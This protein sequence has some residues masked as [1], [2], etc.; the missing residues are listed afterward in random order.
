MAKRF[1][2][3]E[4]LKR[5]WM[6][7]LSIPHK[8]LWCYVL[9]C[10]DIAGVWYVDFGMASFVIGYDFDR[11]VAEKAFEKQIEVNGDRW[12]IKDFISFQYGQMRPENKMFRNVQAKLEAFKEGGSI[13]HISPINGA[14]DK[15][16]EEEK[17][18][19]KEYIG[20]KNGKLLPTAENLRKAG[21]L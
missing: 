21:L 1:T 12:L 14:K 18:K 8:V 13:P 4:K 7:G 20:A 2:D 19:D 10:C 16:K 17:D 3:T 9:D 15:D 5:P 11:S 6:R